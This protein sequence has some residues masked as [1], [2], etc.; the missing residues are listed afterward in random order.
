MRS[1]PW[2]ALLLS[3]AVGLSPLEVSASAGAEP[4][5]ASPIDATTD[6]PSE[7]PQG[8]APQPFTALSGWYHAVWSDGVV[9]L[10]ADYSG[11]TLHC[12]GGEATRSSEGIKRLK[13]VSGAGRGAGFVG[14]GIGEEGGVAIFSDGRW[15]TVRAP[16]IGGEGLVAV[17]V[18]EEGA[19]YAAGERQ[20]LY[21]VRGDDWTIHRYP[22]SLTGEAGE[23]RSSAAVEVL[24]AEWVEEGSL[25][26]VGQRGLALNFASGA[27]GASSRVPRSHGGDLRGAW[28]SPRGDLWLLGEGELLQSPAGGGELRHHKLPVFGSLAALSGV[29]TDAGDVVAVAGQSE[30]VIFDDG[31]MDLVAGRYT[32]P[33]GIFLDAAGGLLYVAH[34][35]G[36]RRLAIEHPKLAP[37]GLP[38]G[39]ACP[40]EAQPES[41]E[42]MAEASS[43]GLVPPVEAPTLEEVKPAKPRR[44][45]SMPIGRVA[46]GVASGEVAPAD[47][48]GEA[49]LGAAF[50]LDV[51]LGATLGVHR[52]VSLWPEVGY[53]Y[54]RLP[55]GANHLFL[56]GVGPLVGGE[57]AAVAVLPRLAVGGSEAF[58]GVG[59]RTGLIGSFAYDMIAVE[60]A[61]Q[62]LRSGGDDLHE[63]RTMVSVNALT[64][65]VVLGIAS[66]FSRGRGRGRLFR[67]R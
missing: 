13:A 64:L 50:A 63:L 25:L 36:L 65:L 31:R 46:L 22:P 14:A 9:L 41:A 39:A 35:D 51:G 62:W 10:V 53:S 42:V 66:V 1:S 4:S 45:Q 59:M 38:V 33:E 52:R 29:H 5:S 54:S 15:R 16:T 57:L 3:V 27:F 61:H 18:D 47:P 58:F 60:V 30:L 43:A 11:V 49:Q 17:A 19:V 37:R 26:L 23:A 32:F 6:A 40:I 21:V 56:A 24:A 8:S 67:R 20:A 44:R 48:G 12:R 28:M 55:G 34:R 7:R 2:W